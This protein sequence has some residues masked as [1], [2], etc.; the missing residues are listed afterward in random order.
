MRRRHIDESGVGNLLED[1]FIVVANTDIAFI[2]SGS[3]RKD[4]PGDDLRLVD[5]PD[6]FPYVDDVIVRKTSGERI[7][8]TPEQSVTLGS[9]L[10]Q[11]VKFG[12]TNYSTQPERRRLVSV[13]RNGAALTDSDHFAVAAPGFLAEAGNLHTVFAEADTI[14]STGKVSGAVPA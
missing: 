13:E 8:R 10:S 5:I 6:T 11:L 12:V 4:L 14:R 7:R 9:G 3:L 2:H 1:A